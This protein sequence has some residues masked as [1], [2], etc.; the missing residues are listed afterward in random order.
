MAHHAPKSLPRKPAV[1]MKRRR[2]DLERG[3]AQLREVQIDG[4]I[5]RGANRGG[6]AGEHRQGCAVN[7]AGGD[8]LHA[9]MAPDD[10]SQFIG[11]V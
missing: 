4:M 6:D 10:W 9:R 7:V 3:L 1:Q 5:G 8:Q 2:F 11:V